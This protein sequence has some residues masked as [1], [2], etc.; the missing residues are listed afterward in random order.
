[1]YLKKEVHKDALDI[2]ENK[3]RRIERVKDGCLN[4]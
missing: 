2:Q 1:M 3:K 4:Y